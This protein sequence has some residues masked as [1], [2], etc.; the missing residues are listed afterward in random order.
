MNV[1]QTAPYFI[2]SGLH[3]TRAHYIRNMVPYDTQP[4]CPKATLFSQD[5]RKRSDEGDPD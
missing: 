5:I 4:K 1:F 3:L 2:D